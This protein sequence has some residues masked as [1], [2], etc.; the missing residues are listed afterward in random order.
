MKKRGWKH[1][2]MSMKSLCAANEET[3]MEAQE[4]EYE[5]IMRGE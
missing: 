2:K 5:I 3:G 1:K 4:D